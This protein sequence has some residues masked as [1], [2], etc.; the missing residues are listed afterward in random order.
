M[1]VTALRV[2]SQSTTATWTTLFNEVDQSSTKSGLFMKKLLALGISNILFW[3]KL[4]PSTAFGERN[5]GGHSLKILRKEEDC[6]AAFKIISWIKACFE[7]ISRNWLR[8]VYLV[9]RDSKNVKTLETY[10]FKFQYV[11][12]EVTAEIYQNERKISGIEGNTLQMLNNIS[13]VIQPLE[14]PP[15][16]CM[17][18]LDIDFFRSSSSLDIPKELSIP[19]FVSIDQLKHLFDER[20]IA[21]NLGGVK[22]AFH[23]CKLQ[24]RTAESRINIDR[25]A[26]KNVGDSEIVE[27]QA[28]SET[29][30]TQSALSPSQQSTSHKRSHLVLSE[31]AGKDGKDCIGEPDAKVSKLDRADKSA[32]GRVD[33][34]LTCP[35]KLNNEELKTIACHRCKEIQHLICY[36]F[37]QHFDDCSDVYDRLEK[38]FLCF[39]CSPYLQEVNEFSISNFKELCLVRQVMADILE[40][41]PMIL[42]N[43]ILTSHKSVSARLI[44]E[45][46]LT[47]NRKSDSLKVMKKSIKKAAKNYFDS[48]KTYTTWHQPLQCPSDAMALIQALSASAILSTF[49]HLADT[50]LGV[51]IA[52]AKKYKA[53]C[54]Y[55]VIDNY[56]NE[57]QGE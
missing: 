28:E 11:T 30:P 8:N 31:E 35:C 32:E 48:L 3:R 47:K 57:Y 12:D 18:S 19:G 21:I 40:N 23:E 25:E 55:F 7:P 44:S 33:L 54:V 45:K 4:L 51:L 49:R 36:G 10:T 34:E 39:N 42:H 38:K 43:S 2:R 20:R 9:I 26:K 24:I 15:L 52:H 56:C 16:P 5:V 37:S 1:S 6:P 14:A 13:A 17:I 50:F 53:A 27:T 29:Q 41:Q 46:I 22:S